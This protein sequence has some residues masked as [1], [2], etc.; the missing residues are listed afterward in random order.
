MDIAF[1]GTSFVALGQSGSILQS[2]SGLT[3]TIKRSRGEG[4]Y[5]DLEIAQGAYVAVGWPFSMRSTDLVNWTEVVAGNLNAVEYANGRFVA[6]GDG[7]KVAVS[8]D[9]GLSWAS[10]SSGVTADLR[11]VAYGGGYWVAV[12]GNGLVIRAP[13]QGAQSQ[14]ANITIHQAVEI[15]WL[16]SASKSYQVKWSYDTESWFD[17][18]VPIMGD[19]AMKSVFDSTRD[20]RKK[21]YRIAQTSPP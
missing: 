21:F 11:G 5:R 2:I 17:F 14:D 18:G 16:A 13:D 3:W 15:R 10:V 1:D 8:S 4:S 9:G 20:A 6:V 12:G 7:G 19:G